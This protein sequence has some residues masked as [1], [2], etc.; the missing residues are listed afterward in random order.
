[1]PQKPIPCASCGKPRPQG[2]KSN[3]GVCMRC[4]RKNWKVTG[5]SKIAFEQ[6]QDKA[7]RAPA[8]SWWA[9]SDYQRDRA[10]ARV[11]LGQQEDR[12]RAAGIGKDRPAL[13]MA[14]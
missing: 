9:T 13:G 6:A 3:K 11:I 7:Q 14:G 2:G 5:K 1:M 8:S 10:A 12:H 4:F